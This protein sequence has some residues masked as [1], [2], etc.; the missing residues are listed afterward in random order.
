[1]AYGSE[2]E[3]RRGSLTGELDARFDEGT[4]GRE[5]WLSNRGFAGNKWIYRRRLKPLH[6]GATLLIWILNI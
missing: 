3:G 5:V 2:R 4:K 6:L 1:M